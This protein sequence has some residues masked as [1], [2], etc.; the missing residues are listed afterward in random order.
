MSASGD[1]DAEPRGHEASGDGDAEP[2]G[3]EASGDGDAEPQGHEASGD[4]VQIRRARPDGHTTS[5]R[6]TE[7]ARAP[8]ALPAR[9]GRGRGAACD[10]GSWPLVSLSSRSQ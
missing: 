2:R 10:M 7:A 1:G 4:R 3:H 5:H 9:A 6:D 8:V